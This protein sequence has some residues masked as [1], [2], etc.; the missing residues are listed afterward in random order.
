MEVNQSQ[1]L[2]Y[3]TDAAVFLGL[4]ALALGLAGFFAGAAFG[5]VL[6]FTGAAF[7][8]PVVFCGCKY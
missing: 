6:F 4:P 5:V 7:L 3:P 1:N 2:G 8:V